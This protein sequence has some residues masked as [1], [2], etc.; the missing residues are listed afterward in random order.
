LF[1]DSLLNTKS[2]DSLNLE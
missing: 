2:T 1:N